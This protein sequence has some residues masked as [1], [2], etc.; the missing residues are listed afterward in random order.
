[1]RHALIVCRRFERSHGN[2]CFAAGSY[3]ARL[4]ST[5]ASSWPIV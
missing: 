2:D 1:M 4:L 5:N 3:A